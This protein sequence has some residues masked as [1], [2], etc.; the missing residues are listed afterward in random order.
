MTEQRILRDTT[1]TLISYPRLGDS[2][3]VLRQ[4]PASVEVK[5][6]TPALAFDETAAYAAGIVDAYDETLSAAALEGATSLAVSSGAIKRG[7]RYLVADGAGG[8]IEVES[9]T[10]G[11]G[12]TMQLAEPLPRALASGA[13]VKGFA[14]TVAL[15]AAQ[16]DM[17]GNGIAEWKAT[18]ASP[19]S[20]VLVWQQ[21]FRIVRRLLLF[22]LTP[23]RLTQV[24]PALMAMRNRQDVDFEELIN[25]TWTHRILPLLAARSI[26]E[27]DVVSADRLEPLHAL[28]CM[29]QV[30]LANPQ[31]PSDTYERF[32]RRWLQLE[33]STF[34]ASDWWKTAQDETPQPRPE[35]QAL[36][37]MGLRLT[38]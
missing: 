16:T 15:T 35:L 2:G 11:T 13:V 38:R 10:E 6:G 33:E 18:M 30:M 24:W 1:Q 26:Q 4:V 31:T 34:A 28:A 17:V 23:S 8:F 29:M 21:S 19:D 22:T 37:V 7:R 25:A 20:R 36:P 3:E 14:C 32:E 9:R 5:I 27:D 12:T